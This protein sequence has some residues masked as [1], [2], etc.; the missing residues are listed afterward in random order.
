MEKK[1]T[2]LDYIILYVED[3]FITRLEVQGILESRY[4]KVYVAKNGIVGLELFKSVC[5]DIIITDIKMPEM[6][7]IKMVINIRKVNKNIPIIVAS[8]FEK[9][10]FKFEELKISDYIIKPIT[11]FTLINKIE[12]HIKNGK[13]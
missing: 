5:P 11:R 3:E 12:K 8:A 4:E 10:F 2:K 9:E 1:L 6:D 13:K 7:G